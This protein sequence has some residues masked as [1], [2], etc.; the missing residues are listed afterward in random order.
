MK[1]DAV[2]WAPVDVALHEPF[3]IAGG[4][5]VCAH[6][7]FVGV[8][9]ASGVVGWGEA[10][11]FPAFNGET[12]DGALAALARARGL[13]VGAEANAWRSVLGACEGAWGKAE[14]ARCAVE[15]AVL[16]A[17]SKA[18][19][20]SLRVW[21]GGSERALESDQ[22][23]TTGTPEQAARSAARI[24]GDGFRTVKLK[25]GGVALRDD[26]ERVWRVV[27]A[28]GGAKCGLLLDANGGMRSV[29]D[30]VLLVRAA[31]S[32]G[33]RVVLFEQPTAPGEAGLRAMAEVQQ[34]SG[35]P[36]AADEGVTGVADVVAHAREGAASVVNIKAMKS[37]L[38]GAQAI[39]EAARGV[40]LRCMIGGLVETSLAMSASAA[41]AAGMGAFAFVDLDTP[42]WMVDEPCCA[43]YRRDGAWLRFGARDE[44]GHGAEPTGA[45]REGLL[46]ALGAKS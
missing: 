2:A 28:V 41:F 26:E 18:H 31:Q 19:S 6:N 35:V 10:A 14:S 29:E 7:V 43:G 1:I 37:G 27:E 42:L 5:Q 32:A 9:L 30:A 33:G 16:D 15:T 23:V 44:G 20:M 34:R 12:R 45:V 39:A 24:A 40:G 36:V 13:L 38:V 3:G 4:A 46:R 17:V 21:F 22:T 11:P 8:R 25:V